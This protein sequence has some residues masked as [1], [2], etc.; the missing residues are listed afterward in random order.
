MAKITVLVYVPFFP[1]SKCLS[2][3]VPQVPGLKF[4]DDGQFLCPMHTGFD[5]PLSGGG[6]WWAG[7]GAE[8]SGGRVWNSL[9]VAEVGLGYIAWLKSCLCTMEDRERPKDKRMGAP[10]FGNGRGSVGLGLPPLS[11]RHLS[12]MK[13]GTPP[14]DGRSREFRSGVNES[15]MEE[16]ERTG[17]DEWENLPTEAFTPLNWK[18]VFQEAEDVKVNGVNGSFRC[19][20]SGE[21]TY[22]MLEKRGKRRTG[23]CGLRT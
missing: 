2:H 13:A 19:Y 20:F 18:A 11:R 23:R 5:V 7:A 4:G 14:E 10:L 21:K 1:S 16:S 6:E 12:A 3:F 8:A 9:G 15:E 22:G 17:T